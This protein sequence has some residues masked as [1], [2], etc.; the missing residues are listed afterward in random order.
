MIIFSRVKIMTTFKQTCLKRH[1]LTAKLD[2]LHKC[3]DTLAEYHLKTAG[4]DNLIESKTREIES[5][6]MD[7]DDRKSL[8][9]KYRKTYF[10]RIT[11]EL[12][13]EIGTLRHRVAD[14]Q[15]IVGRKREAIIE[16]GISAEKAGQLIP[17]YDS[18][19]ALQ[20]LEPLEEELASWV[21]FGETGLASDLPANADEL[22]ERIGNYPVNI[23][24]ESAND[25]RYK[26]KYGT[27]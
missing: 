15:R 12:P 20:L 18:S 6:T 25:Q 17:D 1:E 11:I 13:R 10:D 5:L 27:V 2:A 14:G 9:D 8:L 26:L 23:K 24:A 16:T 21:A 19:S 3:R 4:I 22:F 7:I